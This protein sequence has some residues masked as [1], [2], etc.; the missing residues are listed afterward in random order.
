M[1]RY[2]AWIRAFDTITEDDLAAIRAAR[3]QLVVRPPLKLVARI[4]RTN[5]ELVQDL[6]NSLLGQVYEQW[7]LHLIHDVSAHPSAGGF[8][9]GPHL[10]DKRV[11]AHAGQGQPFADALNDL[12]RSS[13]CEHA[14]II[15]PGVVLRPH[16]LYL[17]AQTLSDHPDT[18]LLYADE[19]SLSD[20]NVRSNHNFKPDWNKELLHSQNYFG[21]FVALRLSLALDVGGFRDEPDQEYSWGLF[22][23]ITHAAQE[24]TIR[25]LPFVLSHRTARKP[26]ACGDRERAAGAQE[27]RLAGLGR[28]VHVVPV[29]ESSY[30]LHY[31][32]PARLP[33]VSV[34]VPSTGN[35]ELLR[36]CLEGVMDRTSYRELEIL[37]VVTTATRESPERR[38][39]FDAVS[40]RLNVRVLTQD[41]RPF[42][43]SRVNNWGVEQARGELVCFLNDDTEAIGRDWLSTMVGYALHDRVAAVGALLYYP[44][45]TIQHAGS[46]LV[47]ERIV[48][49]SYR[50]ER[51]G[52]S[53]YHERALVGQDVSCVTAACI[54][55]RRE[56]FVDVGG[57]NEAIPF[58]FNDVDL[59][60]RLR[61]AGWR[62]VWTPHAEAYHRESV[63]GGRHQGSQRADE[64]RSSLDFIRSR[65]GRELDSDPH[66]NPNL[67]LDPLQVW[68]PAFPPRVSYPWRIAGRTV[69]PPFRDR[70][71]HV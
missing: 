68:E 7:E 54:L 29:G 25:H 11:V 35:L 69:K 51:R 8:L 6:V 16:A 18:T 47:A 55:V 41:H 43:H 14:V 34:I 56:A 9:T 22:L 40:N 3:S 71:T 30:R 10:V 15:E 42:S 21:G 46:V 58:T 49:H 38:D 28:H 37:V 33:T 26:V 64:H 20:D 24:G 31:V 67:S 62:I 53:G 19:D 5:G 27:E 63:S 39:Y 36:P 70:R 4:T 61:E 23:R 45:D 1:A 2:Q 32:L 50:G 13:S 17:V 66:H 59:C 57:F 12:L 52:T 60:M 65:W 48:A 44:N